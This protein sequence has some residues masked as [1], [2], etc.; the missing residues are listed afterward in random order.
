MQLSASKPPPLKITPTPIH[1]HYSNTVGAIT[2]YNNYYIFY[3]PGNSAIKHHC[4][5]E[6]DN[7]V[8]HTG[9]GRIREGLKISFGVP[10]KTLVVLDYDNS[11]N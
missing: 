11:K 3:Y 4:T 2:F 5:V 7:N 1:T 8:D 9:G 10:N 6:C